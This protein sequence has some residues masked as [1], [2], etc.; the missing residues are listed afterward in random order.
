MCRRVV[1]NSD[2]AGIE[3]L[4]QPAMVEGKKRRDVL[5]AAWE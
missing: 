1:S 3:T 2:E 5:D 4:G